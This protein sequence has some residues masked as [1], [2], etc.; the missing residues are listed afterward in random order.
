[1]QRAARGDGVDGGVAVEGDAVLEEQQRA[2]GVAAVRVVD[3]G[4]GVG[5]G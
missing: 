4:G 2:V 5:G 3:V 1:M